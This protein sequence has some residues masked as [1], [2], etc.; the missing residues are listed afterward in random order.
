MLT[1]G[2]GFIFAYWFVVAIC[3][4]ISGS[5]FNPAVTMTFMI[6]KDPGKFTRIL[7][8]AY[9]LAQLAGCFG[10]ALLAFM[11]T[12]NGGLLIVHKDSYIFQA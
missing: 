8:I 3:A 4:N 1:G 6:R 7:G 10:G 12:Q 5:H 11:W 9:I 2:I